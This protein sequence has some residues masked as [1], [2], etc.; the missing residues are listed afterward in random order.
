MSLP[1]N[2]E[3]PTKD[4]N[5]FKPQDGENRVRL[6]TDFHVGFMYWTADSKPVRL[7]KYPT[8]VPTDIRGDSSIK[9]MWLCLV[10]DYTT[11]KVAIWEI[12]QATIQRSIYE[13]EK[14]EDYGDS[15]S[16]DLKINRAGKELDTK[17][18][19]IASPPK[20]RGEQIIKAFEESDLSEGSL[21]AMFS[22]EPEIN[23]EDSP[24]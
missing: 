11:E 5:Y 15:R 12:T 18:N 24:F 2:Y 8:K 1:E 3:V 22:E 20:E 14:D 10:W 19:V 6:L 13:Y 4:S 21:E 17:Y 23:E 9:E 7:K 16:Y